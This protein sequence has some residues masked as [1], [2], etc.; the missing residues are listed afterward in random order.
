M[1]IKC[2]N[3]RN[4]YCYVPDEAFVVEVGQIELIP[5]FS[6]LQKVVGKKAAGSYEEDLHRKHEV[7]KRRHEPSCSIL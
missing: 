4:Y 3:Q 6:L 1:K 2:V 5:F 7:E